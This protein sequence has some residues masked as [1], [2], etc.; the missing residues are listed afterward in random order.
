MISQKLGSGSAYNLL[1]KIRYI[2]VC[3][4]GHSRQSDEHVILR[5]DGCEE[6]NGLCLQIRD[7]AKRKLERKGNE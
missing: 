5:C 2:S 3:L 6:H 1:Q 4:S 7:I